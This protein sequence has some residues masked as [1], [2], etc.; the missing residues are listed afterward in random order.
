MKMIESLPKDAQ[1]KLAE[2]IRDYIAKLNDEMRWDDSFK[3]T[4]TSLVA[5][6]RRAK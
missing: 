6:A 4:Q 1:E 5:A 3:R 2:D